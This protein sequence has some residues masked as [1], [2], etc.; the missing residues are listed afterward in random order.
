MNKRRTAN[1]YLKK[2]KNGNTAVFDEF[3]RLFYGYVHDI[4][5]FELDDKSLADDVVETTFE[6]VLNGI[7]EFDEGKSGY[8]WLVTIAKNTVRTFNRTERKYCL[9]DFD[10]D[11][12]PF[13]AGEYEFD[14]EG[15]Y[16]VIQALQM[17]DPIDR[18]IYWLYVYEDKSIAEIARILGMDYIPVYRRLIKS[19]KKLENFYKKM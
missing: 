5:L 8:A 1:K 14:G 2:L 12:A 18:R 11:A 6:A 19:T 4:A 17:L 3:F 13:G 15:N 10:A 7:S 16:N 9:T